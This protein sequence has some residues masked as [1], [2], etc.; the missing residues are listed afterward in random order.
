LT[1]QILN[2]EMSMGTP[3][4]DKLNNKFSAPNEGGNEDE[5][6]DVH[7]QKRLASATMQPPP[8]EDA[9]RRIKEIFQLA[10]FIHDN[11]GIASGALGEENMLAASCRHSLYLYLKEAIAFKW[12]VRTGTTRTSTYEPTPEFK[13][14]IAI[15]NVELPMP[16]RKRVG[17]KPA[18]L[19]SYEPN[20][21]HYLSQAQR[22]A[23]HKACPVGTFNVSN[24]SVAK[25][26]RRFMADITHNSSVFEGVKIDFAG[27]MRIIG[28][29]AQVEGELS[30]GR[31]TPLD[32]VIVRNHYN[33]IKFIIDNIH[34]PPLPG[35]VHVG[36]YDC[37]NI[38]SQVSDGLLIDRRMQGRTR[39]AGVVIRDSSYLP[40]SDP[41]LISS[42]FAKIFDKASLINDPYEQSVFLLLHL[43]YL[44]PFED[45][46]KRTSRMMCNIPLLRSGILPISWSEVDSTA[47]VKSLLCFYEHG[48]SYGMSEIFVDACERSFERF[49]LQMS[50]HTPA[51]SKLDITYAR[52]IALYVGNVIKGYQQSIPPSVSSESHKEFLLFTQDILDGIRENEMVAAPY[53]LDRTLVNNWRTIQAEQAAQHAAQMSLEMGFIQASAQAS[54][55]LSTQSADA[56]EQHADAYA[57]H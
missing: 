16:K 31:I 46:N 35:D 10:M 38:H 44:Q 52:E 53:H 49:R 43:P 29:L 20:V 54:Q 36:E 7:A 55:T 56:T 9:K 50:T 28:T 15:N 47:Y 12:I 45:C 33:A 17:Y 40:P 4:N 57:V 51:P 42:S 30:S 37:R 3:N 13:H 48:S 19:E 8:K 27:T 2:L 24:P 26:V 14:H 34:F 39:H 5:S 23:L 32:A 21:T 22:E 11:P 6:V 41:K 25:D 18:L 1:E